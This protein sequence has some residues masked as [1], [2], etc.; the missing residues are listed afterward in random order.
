MSEPKEITAALEGIE[1]AS[2]SPRE[3]AQERIAQFRLDREKGERPLP[4][5]NI[6]DDKGAPLL[7][8][9]RVLGHQHHDARLGKR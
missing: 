1:R 7:N 5:T 6:H 8:R 2:K 3:L 9:D 4:T